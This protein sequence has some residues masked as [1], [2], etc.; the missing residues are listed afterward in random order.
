MS[1][2]FFR[3]RYIV[4]EVNRRA[5]LAG[6]AGLAAAAGLIAP[7]TVDAGDP[8]FMNNVPDPL[9]SG[10]DLPT[11]KFALEETKAKV[12][13]KGSHRRGGEAVA[14]DPPVSIMNQS[15]DSFGMA[16][17]LPRGRKSATPIPL[18]VAIYLFQPRKTP[19][20][21]TWHGGCMGGSTS[22]PGLS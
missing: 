18:R 2:F 9:L 12:I 22:H 5:F 21:S 3:G 14:R 1:L 16:N 4:S 15:P 10:K 19:F 20:S 8:S 7:T 13:G 6:T 11:F 17:H